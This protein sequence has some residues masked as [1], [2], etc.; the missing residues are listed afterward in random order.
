[1]LPMIDVATDPS[2]PDHVALME[3]GLAL[4]QVRRRGG[5][6][7]GVMVVGVVGVGVGVV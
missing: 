3:D 1:M 7:G 5:G 2:R 4:W 6:G